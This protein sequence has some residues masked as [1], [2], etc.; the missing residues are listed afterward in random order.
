[1]A[2]LAKIKFFPSLDVKKQ[3]M[4]ACRFWLL[5]LV[6]GLWQGV[7]NLLECGKAELRL[8]LEKARIGQEGGMSEAKW[9][10]ESNKLRAK[11]S[12]NT[13]NIVKNLGDCCAASQGIE[14]PKRFLGFDLND[15]IVG[16]GGFT[17]AYLTCY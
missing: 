8:R 11:R 13:L 17:S 6:L 15:G 10:E 1:M 14:Y 3:T 12:T 2:V 7:H 9:Q 4:M 16:L 5:G